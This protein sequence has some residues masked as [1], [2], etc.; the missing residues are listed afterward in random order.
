MPHL[1]EFARTLEIDPE[2]QFPLM[3][4]PGP[5]LSGQPFFH[6]DSV[7]CFVIFTDSRVA[8][9]TGKLSAPDFPVIGGHFLNLSGCPFDEIIQLVCQSSLFIG[10][11]SGL[12]DLS[13]V[14]GNGCWLFGPTSPDN[15]G[16]VAARVA[17]H[18][19]RRR[20]RRACRDSATAGPG[21]R[22]PGC[23]L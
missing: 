13:A 10:N 4:G 1:Q 6:S 9:R 21:L 12:M 14:I 11:N 5:V 17:A 19:L 7:R 18:G 23:G 15:F 20:P 2:I 16:A 22:V 8:W 3:L